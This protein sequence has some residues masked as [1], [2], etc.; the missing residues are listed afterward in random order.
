MLILPILLLILALFFLF[1]FRKKFSVYIYLHFFMV[2]FFLLGFC[3]FRYY[4]K[5]P[6]PAETGFTF[7]QFKV[8]KW[9]S[10]FCMV[11]MGATL[12]YG[13]KHFRRGAKIFPT[14]LVLSI[15]TAVGS[16]YRVAGHVTGHFLGEVG[17]TRSAFSGLL[18]LRE[19]VKDIDP[20]QVIYLDLGGAHHK[21]R[22][23]VAYVLRDRKLAGNYS[24]DGYILGK[25]PLGQGSIPFS[26]AQWL[27][28]YT[29][30][31]E[32]QSPQE[33][34]AGNLILKKRPDYLVT[35]LSVHGGYAR[36]TDGDSWWHWTSESLEFEYQVL[37]PLKNIQLRFLYM[38]ATKDPDLQ[39]II[40]S[41]K[42]SKVD[43]KMK[44]GW[45]EFTTPSIPIEDSRV[46]IRF[47]SPAKA[48]RV[49]EQD[50]RLMSFLIKNLEL[51]A[52]SPSG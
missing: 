31:K 48:I 16:N 19:M 22:Q 29:R 8:V 32:K 1:Q 43:I 23:M 28:G 4:I 39:V 40:K 21:L 44:G 42:E 45:N 24:D 46:T 49:S 11:L 17:Y 41:K 20:N 52:A 7:L 33:P 18:H 35:L 5:S 51:F 30:M 12:A 26:T 14:F 38:P 3:Y 9:A 34:R 2:L 27:I 10:P 50:P 47:V 37:G 13:Y 6:S 36:E 15:L 25:L